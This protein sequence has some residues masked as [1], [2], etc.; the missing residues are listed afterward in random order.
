MT[1][2]TR[3]RDE[4]GILYSMSNKL[5]QASTPAEWLEAVSDYARDNE[6]AAGIL[7]Y[8][9]PDADG[10]PSALQLAAQWTRGVPRPWAEGTPFDLDR[11]RPFIHQWITTPN[12][13][14][15]VSDAETSDLL[16]TTTR[17]YFEQAGVRSAVILPLHKSGNWI[18]LLVFS[19][20][21]PMLF[22]ERDVRIFTAIIQ[23]A[24]PV[25]AAVRLSDQNRERARRAERL[26]QVNTALSQATNEAQIVGAVALYADQD[27]PDLIM[28]SYV[29]PNEQGKPVQVI[30]VARWQDGAVQ[31]DALR[32]GRPIAIADFALSDRWTA[33]PEE[34]IL[35]AD[36]TSDERVDPIGRELLHLHGLRAVALL[37][38]HSYG[39]WQGLLSIGWREPHVF[40]EQEVTIYTGLLQT[41]PSV[42]A[43]R[44]AYLAAEDA[45]EE[46]EL[47]Y[48]A[49]RGI[50]AARTYQE[51]VDA[52]AQLEMS[53]LSI[54]L[55]VWEA[56][57]FD[58]ARYM[59]LVAKT[60]D[61]RWP[62]GA[63]VLI[64]EIPFVRQ[65]DRTRLL[66]IDNT[67][68]RALLDAT[69]AATTERYGYHSLL[70]VPL[71][72][73]DRFV[74]LLGFESEQPRHHSEREKR[75]AASIGELV[76]AALERIRFREEIEQAR[77][78]A[79]ALARV[80]AALSQATD[81]QAILDAVAQVV[82][83][84]GVAL[85]SLAYSDATEDDPP[86]EV[87]SVALRMHRP[88][89]GDVI[90]L[91]VAS[92]RLDDYPL[93]R[94]TH[95][96][97]YEPV[98]I[99]NVLD[100]PRPDVQ[101]AKSIAQALS[102]PALIA[103]PLMAGDLWHGLLIL[104]WEEPQTF[105]ADLRRL[106]R[107]IR[108]T[109]ASVVTSR[110]AYLAQ[111]EAHIEA[112][113]RALEL[114]TVAKVSA[115]AA[116]IL[117]LERL[118]STMIELTRASFPA[119][120]LDIYLLD[121]EAGQFVSVP[122]SDSQPVHRIA[123]DDPRSLVARAAR[124]RQGVMVNDASIAPEGV[125]SLGLPGARS[126]MAVP[127]I[128]AKQV[129]G[130]LAVQSPEPDRFLQAD[131]RVMST[132]ADLMA[133]A[134][135]NAR[136]YRAAH[137]LAVYEER[138]RL[139]RELHDSV[140]QALYGIALGTRTAQKLLERGPA[141]LAEPLDYVLSLA[142]AGLSEMRALIFE[143][144][145]ELLENDGLKAALAAQVASLQARHMIDV[146]ADLCDEPDLPIAVKEALYRITRE[147]L[148]NTVKHARATRAKVHMHCTPGGVRLE[149]GD[150]GIGFDP[151]A[152]Y[153]GHLGLTSMRERAQA[154]GARFELASAPGQ[155]TH[156]LIE[157]H[158]AG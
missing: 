136:L 150:N 148:N 122:E 109:L 16:D 11:Y 90:P 75:L 111:R 83:P 95:D 134:V 22:N 93:L 123:L 120:S 97:P 152:S 29:I 113:Q 96:A 9:Q 79:E 66:A 31:D 129:V 92:Y 17:R 6:A 100:D 137:D 24:A 117:D 20:R 108:P 87:R 91:P 30:N 71:C 132:L 125:L 145:P 14:L 156:I 84:Y 115:A 154:V 50:N 146:D 144:R 86:T 36:S 32:M 56:F 94:M 38:L 138:N 127:M 126:E 4:I 106:I 1:N 114:E 58:A 99:E 103:L 54:V 52:L 157:V 105:P 76:T 140:S 141:K 101:R 155:G 59:T 34:P 98:F 40:T 48:R 68:D 158:P 5:T 151:S 102:W 49:S 78:E 15:I 42:V 64:D 13:P 133:V 62:L 74:G 147:A 65:L 88:T 47:L 7:F 143:L 26:L 142:E 41:L 131:I 70:A 33:R 57:D 39:R 119:Y 27:P 77:A 107:A 10:E 85:S 44:R 69:T 28:L 110:R 23:Q 104:V 63:R 118:L 12:R 81:E 135:E 53:A 121:A 124:I 55:W 72:L 43:S 89:R 8:I 82:E 149:L 130:V 2:A 112:A 46:R 18:G 128:A 139:A 153:P 60:P 25:I 19:W 67:A 3:P 35:V 80:S 61:N 45:R 37:P 21:E 73:E 51:L 116:H